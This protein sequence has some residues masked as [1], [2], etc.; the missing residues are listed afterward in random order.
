MVLIVVGIDFN[1]VDMIMSVDPERVDEALDMCGRA[2]TSR[3]ISE[4]DLQSLIGKLYHVSICAPGA[5]RFINRFRQLMNMASRDGMTLISGDARLDIAWFLQFLPA[6]NGK[7]VIRDERVDITVAVDFCLSGGGGVS[8]SGSYIARYSPAI[9][10][11]GFG[12]GSLESFN[13]LTAVR[14][15][16]QDWKGLHVLIFVDNMA[17]VNVK[18]I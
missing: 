14:L 16:A 18:Y 1:S 9:L 7:A 12:I 15:W 6:F 13:V 3:A 17:T 5:E 8:P 11:C 4:K 10:S 2:F